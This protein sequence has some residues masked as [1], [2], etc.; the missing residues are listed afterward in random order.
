MK[1]S[2]YVPTTVSGKQFYYFARRTSGS[3]HERCFREAHQDTNPVERAA[4]SRYTYGVWLSILLTK[5][6]ISCILRT[7]FRGTGEMNHGDRLVELDAEVV[8]M[9]CVGCRGVEV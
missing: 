7:V 2:W 4:V 6:A 5:H 1:L 3:C 9:H 8:N